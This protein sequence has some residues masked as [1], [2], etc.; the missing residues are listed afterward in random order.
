MVADR[1]EIRSQLG[2]GG[3]G[4]VFLA[5]DHQ[6][7]RDVALKTLRREFMSN[8]DSI[9]RFEREVKLAHH[10]NHPGI[11][12]LY[13]VYSWNGV[14][15]YTM[16]YV[17]GKTLRCWLTEEK[18]A[19]L[20]TTVDILCRVCDV[21][22][23]A[24]RSTI[25]R[26]LSPDNIMV[27]SDG[28]VRVLDFGLAKFD[29]RFAGLTVAGSNLGKLRYMA[30]EQEQNAA[31]VDRRADL[32]SLGII[33]YELL[34]GHTP[35]VGKKLTRL[36]SDLP[37]ETETFIRKALARKPDERFLSARD[38]REALIRLQARQ[39][40]RMKGFLPFC[41]GLFRRGGAFLKRLVRLGA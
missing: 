39:E 35:K 23:Y 1:Y 22:E 19:D 4:L 40:A 3:M 25:H 16:E 26:D 21:L 20:R 41:A 7:G 34:A 6:L 17:D 37:R 24:H 13:E 27:L 33:F 5:H 30:P 29:D 31:R 14:L 9:A 32:Y 15:F 2:R 12:D 38:F 28:S 36:R 8:P 18:C 10:L 11:V